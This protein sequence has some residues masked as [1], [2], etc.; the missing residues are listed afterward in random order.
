MR[1]GDVMLAHS[2]GIGGWAIGVGEALR[3][4]PKA[5]RWRHAGIIT[6]SEGSTIEA[7]AAGVVRSSVSAHSAWTW[8]SAPAGVDRPVVVAAAAAMLGWRYNWG[9]LAALGI[10]CVLG[11]HLHDASRHQVIC[12]ELVALALICG[13]WHSPKAAS[14]IMP[15][16]LYE[17]LEV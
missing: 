15:A 9:D 11:T 5:A 1:A 10:D 14:E 6:S 8:L 16:D 4:G 13:G 7:T 17:L 2:G 12:S 3:D